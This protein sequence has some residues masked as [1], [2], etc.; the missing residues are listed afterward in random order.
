VPVL[1]D[2]ADP[3]WGARIILEHPEYAVTAANDVGAANIDVGFVSDRHAPHMRPVIGVAQDQ[4]GRNDAV[5]QDLL[6]VIEVVEQQ[7]EGG[8][9]LN[10]AALDLPPFIGGDQP[11]DRIERQDAVDRGAL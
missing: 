10:D 6:F 5:L 1:D 4:F 11:R 3:G 2:I 7:V 8:D 9:P